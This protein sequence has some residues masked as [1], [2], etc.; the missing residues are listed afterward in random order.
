MS[1]KLDKAIPK[2]FKLLV[3]TMVPEANT[4]DRERA[5]AH[6]N[7]TLEGL[8][9]DIHGLAQ[10]IVDLQDEVKR[11][12]GSSS[13]DDA[14]MQ[15]ILEAGI[16]RGREEEAARHQGSVV[17]TALI[18]EDDV[19]TGVGAYTWQTLVD[20]FMANQLRLNAWEK[21]FVTSLA[22]QLRRRHA[23][24]VKQAIRLEAILQQ[25]FNG[26]I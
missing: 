19:G 14:E 10:R 18:D 15:R 4:G 16:A 5:V 6:F 13:L 21:N 7:K 8:D 12:T 2:L 22:S 23:P 25:R 20:H 11:G 1:D 24:S 17:T 9:T 3:L 26:R